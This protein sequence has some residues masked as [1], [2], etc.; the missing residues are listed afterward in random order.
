MAERYD[1]AVIGGGPVGSALALELAHA[2]RSVVL[3]EATAAGARTDARPLALS[4]GS[5]LILERLDAWNALEKP[6]PI[7]RI[8]ISQRGAYG[9]TVLTAADVKVPA[10]GYVVDYARLVAALDGRVARSAVRVFRGARV[11]ALHEEGAY[12][13]VEWLHEGVRAGCEASVVAVADGSALS[14]TSNV[15][16]VDYEQSAVTALVRATLPHRN[17]A[18]ERF[19]PEGPLALLPAQDEYAVVWSVRPER[20]DALC[21]ASP[22]AFLACLQDRF[23]D[24]AGRLTDVRARA[25]H[26]LTLRVAQSTTQSARHSTP[27]ARTILIGNAAQALHPVAGQGFNLGLRD[28]YELAL[29]VGRA[30][31]ARAEGM[32]GIEGI[33]GR[34][35]ARAFHARRR[36]DRTGGIMFTDALVRIFSNDLLPLELARGAGLTLLDCIP[37]AKEFVARRMIF[38]ARG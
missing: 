24:R 5:R 38:G 3:L 29:E 27:M 13:R 20:A 17:T 28:A 31:K 14:S 25:A 21:A 19:T 36:I 6:T 12:A 18:Y 10:L 2:G 9:R 16:V 4:Y 8:H 26:K 32:K 35:I 30:A 22:A 37:P 34:D 1:V 33:D 15:R 11:E 23:G 7:A